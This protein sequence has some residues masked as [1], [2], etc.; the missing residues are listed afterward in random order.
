MSEQSSSATSGSASRHH[1]T[2]LVRAGCGACG[3]AR[4]QL[5]A[6]QGEGEEYGEN[7]CADGDGREEERDPVVQEVAG[8]VVVGGAKGEWGGKGVLP[9]QVVLREGKAWIM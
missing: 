5:E 3:P 7:V 6:G 9:A 8:G 2:L 4:E 1:L